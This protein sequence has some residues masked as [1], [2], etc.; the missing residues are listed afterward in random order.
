MTPFEI[1]EKIAEVLVKA[2][3]IILNTV[4]NA[5]PFA[6]IL[7]RTLAKGDKITEADLDVLEAKITE[8]SNQLQKPLSV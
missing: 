7:Y 3:P 2:A 5:K 8:L 4:Q 1:A 6:E